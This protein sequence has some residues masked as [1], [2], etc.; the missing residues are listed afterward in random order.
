ML[1][2]QNATRDAGQI[3]ITSR[4][5]NGD[6]P[7][8]NNDHLPLLIYHGA[9]AE[10][11]DQ[12]V[13]EILR[14][15]GWVGSWVNGIYNYHHFH[16]TAHEVLGVLKG[17]ADVQL[18]GPRGVTIR[19]N[20]GDI[21][22]IPAGVSHKCITSENNFT[23]IGA[24]PRGQKYNIMKGEQSQVQEASSNISKVPL[25]AF[26]PVYGDNGPLVKLWF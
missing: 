10:T 19:I 8:P 14:K 17:S 18:G 25:P 15:N 23:V 21:I 1:S 13:E 4:L 11:D 9:L 6:G 24:Y 20:K 7:F 5:L 26:D 12:I 2:T 22:V 16:S 3:T